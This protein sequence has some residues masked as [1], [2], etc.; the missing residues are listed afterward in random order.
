MSSYTSEDMTDD[1]ATSDRPTMYIDYIE[2]RGNKCRMN[3]L[4]GYGLHCGSC[5]GDSYKENVFID[6]CSVPSATTNY[7]DCSGSKC[8]RSKHDNEPGRVHCYA[9]YGSISSSESNE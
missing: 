7:I 1:V 4:D 8:R 6:L 9:C 2:C 5:Y 3:Y